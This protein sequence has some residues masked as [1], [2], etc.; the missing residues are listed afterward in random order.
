MDTD[1]LLH[2]IS[3]MPGLRQWL[4]SSD[5][6]TV[7]AITPDGSNRRLYRLSGPAVPA[8][9][10]V[11]P[12]AEDINGMAESASFIA[13]AA[14]LAACGVPVPRLYDSDPA[15]GLIVCDDLGDTRLYEAVTEPAVSAGER[16][17][18]YEQTVTALAHM[19]VR[20]AE[21]FDP[22]WCWDSPRYDRRLMLERE[23]GYFLQAF[24]RDLLGLAPATGPLVADFELLAVRAAAAPP[25][26][27]LHRDFQSRNIMVK[28]G[29]VWFID[30][31]GGRLG[32]LAYDLASLL[33]DPYVGL[34]PAMQLHLFEVYL[35]RL[36][37]LIPYDRDQFHREYVYLALQRNLQILGAFAFLS[38]VRGKTFFSQFIPPALASLRELLAK[39]E[40]A[41][42]A[43]LREVAAQCADT[44]AS[45][46][47][48]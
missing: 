9:I 29:E 19:Q 6:P 11:A 7:T 47:P 23:S 13:I 28:E 1:T 48:G 18:L 30:F 33:I 26:Y 46:R 3:G 31:Q 36:Q 17:V 4:G 35:D 24:C 15:S 16:L 12:A 8:V 42:Y 40:A 10:A 45:R 38:T 27:F 22:S 21:G 20:G 37:Q 43:A 2:Q 41:G 14:H 34:E 32:P 39:P 25:T 44:I 5:R